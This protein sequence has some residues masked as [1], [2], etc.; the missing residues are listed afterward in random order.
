MTGKDIDRLAS[1]YESVGL[2]PSA[3]NS[4]GILGSPTVHKKLEKENVMDSPAETEKKILASDIK[5][6][7]SILKK[8]KKKLN[9]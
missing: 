4:Q 1:L 8:L 2:G 3:E 9:K 7:A 6:L 5:K